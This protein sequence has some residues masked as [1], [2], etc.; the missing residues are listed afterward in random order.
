MGSILSRKEPSDKAGTVHAVLGTLGEFAPVD[1]KPLLR[2]AIGTL[3]D[4]EGAE[5]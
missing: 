1:T 5:V 4:E 2:E 3:K